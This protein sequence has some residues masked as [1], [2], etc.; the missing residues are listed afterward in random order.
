MKRFLTRLFSGPADPPARKSNT[1]RPRLEAFEDRTVPTTLNVTTTLDSVDIT[2][3]KLSLREAIARANLPGADVIVLPAGVFKITRPGAGEFE[4][5]F[6]IFD[7]VTIRGAGA[8]LTIVDGQQ[9]DRV[10]DVAGA[11]SS[12][13]VV[14]EKLTVR[15]GSV[16]DDGGGIRVGNADLVVRD[17]AV[18]GNRAEIGGGL[19]NFSDP[20]TSNFKLVRTTVSRNVAGQG[21]GGVYLV[22]GGAL[23]LLQS[24]VRRNLAGSNG[25]G[26]NATTVTLTR[27][28]VSGNAA[29][30]GF[31][32]GIEAGGTVTLTSS[33]VSGNSAGSAG[34]GIDADSVTLTSSTVSG[35]TAGDHGGGVYAFSTATLTSST[36][37]GNSAGGAGGGV[38]AFSTATLTSSTVS[39]NSAG[40]AGG[41]IFGADTVTL[42]SS[43]VSGNSSGSIGG[44]IFGADTVTL[45]SSTVSGNSAAGLAA[46]GGIYAGA[47]VTLT[48]SSVSGNSAGGYGGGIYAGATAT[49]TS[50]TVGGN[51]AGSGGGIFAQTTVTLTSS[52]VSGNSAG[53]SG[54]GIYTFSTATL[55]NSTVSGNFAVTDGGGIWAVSATLLNVTVTENTAHTGGGVFHFPGGT[56]TVKN[57]LIAQNLVDFTG[58]APDVSGDFT[59]QGHNLIGDGTGGTGFGVNFDIVG[60]AANP[61]DPRLGPLANN[62]GPTKTHALLAG[63]PAIDHGDNAGLPPTD[64]RGAGFVRNKDGNG[65]GLAIVD[66]GAYER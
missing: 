65:D 2:D 51:R 44:G 37:S 28:T 58:T 15:N 55:T 35:N 66:I 34:G 60:T 38:Y 4:G 59:S 43:T 50:S 14:L 13:K 61:I 3:G 11:L 8:G 22:G 23:T 6:G 48:R 33:T 10:F 49:L 63:S 62:G 53:H 27:S 42:T 32:G 9:L 25:G 52:T 21:G 57:T 39:G 45:T 40:G 7:A 16:T 56:F 31:G 19:S 41:G 5:D 20:G 30:S 1:F 17:C 12:I 29:V 46:G 26:I 54:G 18:T 36:V 24:T 64:E 47:T